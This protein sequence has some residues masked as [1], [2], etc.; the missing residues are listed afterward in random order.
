MEDQ[1]L[2]GVLLNLGIVVIAS[3]EFDVI[4]ALECRV[5]ERWKVDGGSKGL[6]ESSVKA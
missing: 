3:I 4:S 6:G 2:E 5:N 1:N